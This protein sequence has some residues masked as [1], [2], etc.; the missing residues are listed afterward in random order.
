MESQR[1][2]DYAWSLYSAFALNLILA[3]LTVCIIV[4]VNFSKTSTFNKLTMLPYY[5]VLAGCAESAF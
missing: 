3:L 4:L 2:P 5:L 1:R